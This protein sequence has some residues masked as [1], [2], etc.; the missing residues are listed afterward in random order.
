[1]PEAPMNSQPQWMLSKA[2][3]LRLLGIALLLWTGGFV[4]A[5]ERFTPG[6]RALQPIC[7]RS[8]AGLWQRISA[9][10]GAV[11]PTPPRVRVGQSDSVYPGKSLAGS[12]LADILWRWYVADLKFR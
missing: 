8:T 3:Y 11:D 2:K 1:M 4:G 9:V 5:Y 10:G 7:F 12:C 6:V